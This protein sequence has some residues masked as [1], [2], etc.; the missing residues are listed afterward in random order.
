MTRTVEL[1]NEITGN[2]DMCFDDSALVSTNNFEF[3]KDGDVYDCF[4]K[5]FGEIWDEDNSKV[6]KCKIKSSEIIGNRKFLKVSVDKEIYYV[7]ET[8]IQ[9][10]KNNEFLFAYT[11]KDLIKVNEVIHDD[12]LN[13]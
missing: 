6:V 5:L 8:K 11:R 7:P 1:E 3:M 2:R 9:N 13:A 4:I 10:V 12:L